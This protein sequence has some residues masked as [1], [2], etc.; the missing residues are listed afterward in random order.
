M[1]QSG[2]E[3]GNNAYQTF[4]KFEFEP[5]VNFNIQIIFSEL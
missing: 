5:N 3:H 4:Q 2:F 1:A